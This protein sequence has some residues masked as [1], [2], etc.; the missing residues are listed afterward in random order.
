MEVHVS[1]LQNVQSQMPS[2]CREYANVNLDTDLLLAL[3]L[4]QQVYCLLMNLLEE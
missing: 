3:V 2:V 4:A 1:T